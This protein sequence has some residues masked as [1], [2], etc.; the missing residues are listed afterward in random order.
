M[1]ARQAGAQ[2]RLYLMDE[3][4]ASQYPS[5]RFTGI[6]EMTWCDTVDGDGTPEQ[7]RMEAS[8]PVAVRARWN[9]LLD[10]R[11]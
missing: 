8:P 4:L 6:W 2:L 10:G 7:A 3:A 1:A 9:R 5:V 11:P